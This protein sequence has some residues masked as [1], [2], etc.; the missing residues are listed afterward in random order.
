LYGVRI[1]NTAVDTNAWSITIQ[2]TAY[3][4]Q[5][6]ACWL[7]ATTSATFGIVTQEQANL[8]GCYI[9]GGA[10]GLAPNGAGV[11]SFC[12]FD[13]QGS[14]C[15]AP[16]SSSFAILNCSFYGPG[17]N[18]V[19]LNTIPVRGHTIAN[20]H[21]ENCNQSGKAAINNTTGA[22]SLAVK[23]IN[24]SF[25]NCTSNIL[26]IT[27]TFAVFDKGTLSGSGFTAPGSHDFTGTT[28][29]KAIGYPGTLES[30]AQVGYLDNGALQ[31]QEPA[32][33]GAIFSGEF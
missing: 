18:G 30:L 2:S 16:G 25:Y 8:I 13:G 12:V 9:L 15:I 3:G 6:V 17:G 19:N 11:A 31:R 10:T 20:C 29:L 4:A 28:A 5:I 23:L 26:N 1:E 7:K 32:G 21:F 22:N 14:D 24:N 27:E 33:G